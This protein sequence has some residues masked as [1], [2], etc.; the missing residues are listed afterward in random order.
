MMQDKKKIRL[1]LLGRPGRNAGDQPGL[2][3]IRQPFDGNREQDIGG[4]QHH[5]YRRRISGS[6]AGSLWKRILSIRKKSGSAILPPVR[7]AKMWTAM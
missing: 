3:P 4:K 5:F 6:D 1:L 2:P 7:F